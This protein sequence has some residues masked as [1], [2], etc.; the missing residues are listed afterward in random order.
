MTLIIALLVAP[1]TALTLCF[2]L[3][4]FAGLRPSATW[5][6]AE[7]GHHVRS[8]IVIPAHNEEAILAATLQTLQQALPSSARILLVADNCIDSTPAIASQAGVQVIERRDTERRGK[9]FALDFARN[10]LKA[11]PPD[12]V[13]V[14][15]ADCSIDGHSMAGLARTCAAT[16]RPCQATNLQ[17]P[18]FDGSIAVQ[19]STFAFFIKNVIRQRG[20]QRLAGRANLLGTGMAFPWAI[21]RD[22]DL[23]TSNIAEDMKLGHDL[24]MT[25]H[26]PLFVEQATVWSNAETKA[27]TLSQRRRWEGGFLRNALQTGPRLLGRSLL[28]ADPRGVWGAIHVMIP[29]LALLVVLD[30]AAAV[31]AGI[32]TLIWRADWWPLVLLGGSMILA[33]TAVG[34]A[35]RAGGQRFI[36]AAGL[37]RIPLY[38]AWKLPMYLGF[39]RGGAPD[40]WQR[41][42]RP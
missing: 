42:E 40:E 3:E 21:F 6:F 30:L 20:L 28:Q 1:L 19:M 12:V 13:V 23:A 26:A 22:A 29:P 31:V 15:D 36:T 5:L 18:A 16:A 27:N 11:D 41:T 14:I 10:H 34:F 32:R 2:A 8:T 35:W 33:F 9:G 39:L 17:K 24:A 7:P 37:C 4:V 38:V 25:G